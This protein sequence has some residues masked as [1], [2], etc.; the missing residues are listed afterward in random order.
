M[1]IQFI[2]IFP[3]SQENAQIARFHAR[4]RNIYSWLKICVAEPVGICR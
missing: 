2:F 4:W 1:D 3:H